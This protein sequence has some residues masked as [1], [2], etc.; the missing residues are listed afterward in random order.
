MDETMRSMTAVVP[1][2]RTSRLRAPAF[3]ALAAGALLLGVGALQEWVVLSFPPAID[4][5]GASDVPVHGVDVW[6]GK[7]V[8]GAA[9]AILGLTVVARSYSSGRRSVAAAITALGLVAAGIAIVVTIVADARFLA[10]DG[11]DAFAEALSDNLGVPV[12]EVRDALE[13]VARET[14]EVQ[15]GIGLWLSSAGGILAAMGG[16]LTFGSVRRTDRVPPA[17]P[18]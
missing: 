6:E 16:A 7:V 11:L 8:F 17:D 10:A 12:A 13:Q 5:V 3:I 9:I 4:P 15:R 14:L 2:A 1:A 18:D